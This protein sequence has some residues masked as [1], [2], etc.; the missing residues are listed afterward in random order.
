M[1]YATEPKSS[2]KLSGTVW[3]QLGKE[4]VSNRT[5]LRKGFL[6]GAFAPLIVGLCQVLPLPYGGTCSF[7]LDI[8]LLFFKLSRTQTSA[9]HVHTIIKQ[10]P[11]DALW[12]VALGRPWHEKVT[13][14]NTCYRLYGRG[15]ACS[16]PKKPTILAC[17]LGFCRE[18]LL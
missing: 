1:F 6:L 3:F 12:S 15:F 7:S 5:C 10:D 4:M 11:S 2:T 17:S 8:F 18:G 16:L 13:S 9:T 14:T